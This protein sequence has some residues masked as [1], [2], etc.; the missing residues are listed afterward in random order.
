MILVLLISLVS[1]SIMLSLFSHYCSFSKLKIPDKEKAV[2][3][4]KPWEVCQG[5]IFTQLF[6]P[7]VSL[8]KF[9]EEMGSARKS[10]VDCKLR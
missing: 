2:S 3:L 9:S 7:I 10:S 1:C 8:A 4:F 5:E 6:T